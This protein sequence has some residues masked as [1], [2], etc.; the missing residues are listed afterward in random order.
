MF[1]FALVSSRNCALGDACNN[2]DKT[3]R[4]QLVAAALATM[5]VQANAGTVSAVKSFGNFEATGSLDVVETVENVM[6]F[7]EVGKYDVT[8]NTGGVLT[9]FGV[10]NN[11][12]QPVV[13]GDE[14][15]E[16]V[17][18]DLELIDIPLFLLLPDAGC[19]T[20][21][22]YETCY[23]SRVLNS[24]N[25]NEEIAYSTFDGEEVF[26]ET[27]QDIF[28]DFETASG[29]DQMFNWFDFSIVEVFNPRPPIAQVFE[30]TLEEVFEPVMPIEFSALK[31]GDT[32]TDFFGFF[33]NVPASSI[34]GHS[35]V[36]AN[37][38]FYTAGQAVPPA[39]PLPA[40]AW[41]LIAG[42]GGLGAIARRKK[43]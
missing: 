1:T 27:F 4:I 32:V 16:N 37:S 7:G 5:A 8:N 26:E 20:I 11:Y 29:G 6:Y 43:A 38:S 17:G 40:A 24:G 19:T 36:G 41:M 14:F 3:M 31:D 35:S 30:V 28:G 42:I 9:G 10:S 12:T 22:N 21:G 15:T 18:N 13:V 39:V 33:G 25:W 34:I 2:W 23:T